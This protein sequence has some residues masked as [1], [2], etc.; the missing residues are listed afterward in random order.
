[1]TLTPQETL[2]TRPVDMLLR[3]TCPMC[4]TVLEIP[5]ARTGQEGPCPVCGAT[6]VAPSIVIAASSQ[7]QP[8]VLGVP[9]AVEPRPQDNISKELGEVPVESHA[10]RLCD[11]PPRPAFA[12]R[13]TGNLPEPAAPKMEPR[14]RKRSVVSLG[15]PSLSQ[16]L[17]R[18]F[19]L[20]LL[21]LVVLAVG[22]GV[23]FA[24]YGDAMF[25][26]L[27]SASPMQR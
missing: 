21:A 23:A 6:I 7:Q 12:A 3:F 15:K 25:S 10:T 24:V 11:L 18:E 20:I 16:M 17:K 27:E 2:P 9:A 1:M 22:V 14:R 19:W 13:E 5:R 8:A 26:G 4:S